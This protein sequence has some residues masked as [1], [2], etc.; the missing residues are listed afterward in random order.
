MG[1]GNQRRVV[2]GYPEEAEP[3]AILL[4]RIVGAIQ[5]GIRLVR[6]VDCVGIVAIEDNIDDYAVLDALVVY[7]HRGRCSELETIYDAF[8]VQHE[9]PLVDQVECL[10]FAAD[11][12]RTGLVQPCGRCNRVCHEKI[13]QKPRHV[14]GAFTKKNGQW[15]EISF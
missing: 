8:L 12:G 13:L 5:E 14:G 2:I 6:V 10:V 11:T 3:C 15:A 9:D 4:C 1:R 7:R